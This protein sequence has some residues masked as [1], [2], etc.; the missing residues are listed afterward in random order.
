MRRM[1]E[2]G[3]D[4][5][6]IESENL[7]KAP[8]SMC[9][10]VLNLSEK[11]SVYFQTCRRNHT[12][13]F[14]AWSNVLGVCQYEIGC[15]WVVPCCPFHTCDALLHASAPAPAWAMGALRVYVIY[16]DYESLCK[17]IDSLHDS[18]NALT[19]PMNM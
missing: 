14:V 16:H 17:P 3:T 4:E 5:G 7:A 6:T 18:D 1:W 12:I 10:T 13:Y 11:L 9:E 15:V 2:R 19:T 8:S